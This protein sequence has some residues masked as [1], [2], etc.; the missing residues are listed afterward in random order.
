MSEQA[1]F[2]V[3]GPLASKIIEG[4]V[5][6]GNY[7]SLLSRLREAIDDIKMIA[8]YNDGMGIHKFEPLNEKVADRVIGIIKSHIP[9]AFARRTAQELIDA[10]EHCHADCDGEC[11][12]HE[13]PQ[14][15]EKY[16]EYCPLAANDEKEYGEEK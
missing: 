13:C 15:N 9:E 6:A 12:W 5:K 11:D 16:R 4:V 7:N 2:S 10:G 8:E 3:K 1:E 14:N